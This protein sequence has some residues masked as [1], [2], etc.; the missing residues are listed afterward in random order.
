MNPDKNKA[1]VIL[2]TYNGAKFINETLDSINNQSYN[3]IDVFIR[4]DGSTD[5]TVEL[6]KSFIIDKNN[7]TLLESNN[8]NLG[9]PGSFYEILRR[10]P[11]TYGY[12]F[13]ADQDDYWEK[14][15]IEYAIKLLNDQ[16]N[17]IPKVYFSSFEYCD[18][19]LNHIRYSS[20]QTKNCDFY[21]SLFYTLGLGFTIAFNREAFNQF[22]K[23]V[24]PG[25]EMHDRWIIRCASA[26]GQLVY[27]KRPTAKHIRH[28]AA[29]TASDNH[30]IDLFKYFI[31][32]ELFGTK[33]QIEAEKLS[34]FKYCFND[35][36]NSDELEALN[37]FTEAKGITSQLKKALFPHRLRPTFISE[38]CLR[39][40]FLIGKI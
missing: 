28:N 23:N 21:H 12:Y 39:F 20:D 19:D 16:H 1:C 33:A 25:D 30:L 4:D 36:L 29:V 32:E 6:I 40:L 9:V 14:Q 15:K 10:I 2:P 22:I 13:Y 5:N 35:K 3:N 18:C 8:H 27:D 37:L 17:D 38:F 31:K 11:F 34:H 24:N 7:F 26:L